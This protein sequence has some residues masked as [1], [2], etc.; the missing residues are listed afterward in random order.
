MLSDDWEGD[1]S[2]LAVP[3]GRRIGVGPVCSLTFGRVLGPTNP[4]LEEA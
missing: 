2:P 1:A 3:V 4:T